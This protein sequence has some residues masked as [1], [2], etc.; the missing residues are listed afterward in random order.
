VRRK[1]LTQDVSQPRAP[2]RCSFPE[3]ISGLGEEEELGHS[4]PQPRFRGAIAVVGLRRA[5]ML[6]PPGPTW[7][8][9][10]AES[11]PR[12]PGPW[13]GGGAVGVGMLSSSRSHAGPRFR[14]IVAEAARTM[15]VAA[16]LR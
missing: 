6:R 7:D 14:G 1:K 12:P 15:A 11:P 3:S 16:V 13:Q 5:H 9:D 8:H 10:S 4:E 2:R